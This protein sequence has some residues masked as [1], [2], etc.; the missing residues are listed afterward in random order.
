[1]SHYSVL[2]STTPSRRKQTITASLAG[3]WVQPI[4]ASRLETCTP[5]FLGVAGGTASGKTCVVN[6]IVELLGHEGVAVISQDCYYRGLNEAEREDAANYNFDHPEAFN[7]DSISETLLAL[8]QRSASVSVPQYDFT[9]HTQ[10]P[11]EYDTH[12]NSP[13]IVIFEGILALH[14]PAVRDL[15]DMKV[16]VDTDADVRLARRIKRDMADRGRDLDGIL[17][18]YERFVKPSFDAY[19]APQRQ[20]ADVVLP[21]GLENQVGIQMVVENLRA[22]LVSYEEEECGMAEKER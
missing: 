10:M 17:M 5:F 13:A 14:S 8:R 1:M 4:G 7:F 18:Q 2:S 11:R 19:C 22:L 3:S 16:F 6:R 15:L 12:V 20:Y 9:T 21:R